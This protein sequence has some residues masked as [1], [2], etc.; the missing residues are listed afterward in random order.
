[1]NLNNEGNIKIATIILSLLGVTTFV[2]TQ[3]SQIQSEPKSI[4]GGFSNIEKNYN[5]AKSKYVDQPLSFMEDS[6]KRVDELQ[7]LNTGNETPKVLSITSPKA[8]TNT[9]P[10]KSTSATLPEAKISKLTSQMV[11]NCKV[12]TEEYNQLIESNKLQ[13]TNKLLESNK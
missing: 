6:K 8:V 2:V 1:M 12:I 10:I 4:L 13:E 5:E 3:E 9:S 7:I 11:E